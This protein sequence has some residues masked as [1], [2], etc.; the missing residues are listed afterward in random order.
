LREYE[1][2]REGMAGGREWFGRWEREVGE[3]K[4]EERE[5]NEK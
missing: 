1:C 3:I 5:V 4:S 2:E